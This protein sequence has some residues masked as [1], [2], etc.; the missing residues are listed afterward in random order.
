MAQ[1][2]E[3][4]FRISEEKI[5]SKAVSLIKSINTSGRI[6]WYYEENESGNSYEA[7]FKKKKK[8]ISIEFGLKGNLQDVE[9]KIKEKEIPEKAQFEI[10]DFLDKYFSKYRILKI[11]QQFIDSAETLVNKLRNN[12]LLRETPN[13][14]EIEVY[15]K[16]NNISK[17]MEFRFDSTGKMKILREIIPNNSDHLEY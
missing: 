10:R 13:Y 8:K 14:Y 11:Q 1:K 6:K 5:P 2:R 9:I 12:S 15:G 3:K 17:M 4:E 16:K 7:K